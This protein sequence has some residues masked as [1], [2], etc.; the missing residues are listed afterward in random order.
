MHG[1]KDY[2]LTIAKAVKRLEMSVQEEAD[3][4]CQFVSSETV[5][6]F[7]FNPISDLYRTHMCKKIQVTRC[8]RSTRDHR[9]SDAIGVPC[10]TVKITTDGNCFFRAISQTI[11]GTEDHH[12]TLRRVA[13]EH[14]QRN[15]GKYSGF[16]RRGVSMGDYIAH[17][18][19]D[20]AGTWASEVE[21]QAMAELFYVSIYTYFN[22]RWLRY[23]PHTNLCPNHGIYLTNS[24]NHFEVVTCVKPQD[25]ERCCTRCDEPVKDSQSPNCTQRYDGQ[26]LSIEGGQELSTEG[27]KGECQDRSNGEGDDHSD[28]DCDDPSDSDRECD[29][30]YEDKDLNTYVLLERT[31]G[32]FLNSLGDHWWDSVCESDIMA[33]METAEEG[34]VI[35][36]A[37]LGELGG[38]CSVIVKLSR[39]LVLHVVIRKRSYMCNALGD[40][41]FKSPMSAL[42]TILKQMGGGELVPKP[43]RVLSNACLSV[44]RILKQMASV[45][46]SIVWWRVSYEQSLWSTDQRS[47]VIRTLKCNRYCTIE[48]PAAVIYCRDEEN[49]GYLFEILT[50]A[51]ERY[52]VT[53]NNSGYV[54]LGCNAPLFKHIDDVMRYMVNV[55]GVTLVTDCYY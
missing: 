54:I 5:Q 9:C 18:K 28:S 53:F 23:K 4:D 49:S 38:V 43:R 33:H 12:D 11:A 41:R 17:S 19:M 13:V 55:E 37:C 30:E 3:H 8:N 24:A 16:L 52:V 29:E 31:W 36:S 6:G 48:K 10:R 26:E 47:R 32:S 25:L 50:A 7:Q 39:V 15:P 42:R 14:L 20:V 51:D 1:N 2:T 22:E 34:A 44:S 27:G 35:V 40:T 45:V 21:I 46:S